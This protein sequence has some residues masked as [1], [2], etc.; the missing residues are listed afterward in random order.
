[1]SNAAR[2]GVVILVAA[3]L[4]GFVF[5]FGK[6][7]NRVECLSEISCPDYKI[8]GSLMAAMFWPLTLSA[9][10]QEGGDA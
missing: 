7:F 4:G 3:Y 5:T 2:I 8:A 1:M 9:I 6:M 10:A